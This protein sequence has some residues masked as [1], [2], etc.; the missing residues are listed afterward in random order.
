MILSYYSQA[1]GILSRL[2]VRFK[3]RNYQLLITPN[4][5]IF[6]KR[7]QM[8]LLFFQYALSALFISSAEAFSTQ[9]VRNNYTRPSTQLQL[10]ADNEQGLVLK[11]TFDMDKA[12]LLES[13]FDALNDKDKYDAVLTGLCSKILDG[14][15]EVDP[16][17]IGMEAT[18]SPSQLALEKMKD[19][20]R[21]MGEMNQRK[22]KASSR[23]LMALI[24]VSTY[25]YDTLICLDFVTHFLLYNI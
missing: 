11:E 16:A 4:S 2:R 17:Q 6:V 23:S 9:S 22:V 12:S 5:D 1:V 24:D 15:I 13:A 7:L 14:K 18:L 20:I 19:P 21:L 10:A 25:R 3:I 8:K